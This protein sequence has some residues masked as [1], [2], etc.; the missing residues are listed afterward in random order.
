MEDVGGRLPGIHEL[1][2]QLSGA[3]KTKGSYISASK[4]KL[5]CS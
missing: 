2:L 3:I 5:M 1:W 4:I